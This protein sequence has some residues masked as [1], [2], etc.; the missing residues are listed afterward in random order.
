MDL[1]ESSKEHRINTSYNYQ[2]IMNP[3]ESLQQT[4]NHQQP[5]HLVVDFGG[6]AVTGIH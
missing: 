4:L 6:T 5:D 2:D 1:K 3:R